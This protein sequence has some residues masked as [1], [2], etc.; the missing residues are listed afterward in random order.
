M[1]FLFF[2]TWTND[3]GAVAPPTV[4]EDRSI[5]PVWRLMGKV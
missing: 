1:F 2:W 5:W 3:A 4:V